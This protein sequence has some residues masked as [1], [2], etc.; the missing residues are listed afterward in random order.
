[1][2]H[3]PEDM[4]VFQASNSRWYFWD[5]TRLRVIGGYSDKVEAQHW[6]SEYWK[7]LSLED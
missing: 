5:E 4:Y 2:L 1:M 6:A 3:K 7:E